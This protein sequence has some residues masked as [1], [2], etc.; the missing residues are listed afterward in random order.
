[1][2]K[3]TM[4]TSTNLSRMLRFD[5]IRWTSDP[6]LTADRID[7]L[8][9]NDDEL[10]RYARAMQGQIRADRRVRSVALALIAELYDSVLK[11]KETNRRL[12]GEVTQLREF[13]MRLDN[14][15]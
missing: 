4:E 3:T 6:L 1:M 2:E 5:D 13:V 15:A 14:V 11:H 7:L 10:F 8:T 9:L 12:I